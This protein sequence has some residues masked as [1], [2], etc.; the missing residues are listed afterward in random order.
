MRHKRKILVGVVTAVVVVVLGYYNLSGIGHQTIQL[1][2]QLYGSS[3]Y[4][5]HAR[6]GQWPT[7]ADDL[8][9]TPLPKISPYWKVALETGTYVILWPKNLK[10][11]PKD[12]ANVILA[13]HNQGLLASMGRVWVCWGDLRTEYITSEELRTHLPAD[14]E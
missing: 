3:I 1:H 7:Q 14:R 5:Y 10:A 13:Y 8:A 2:L 12:N 9:K 11:D 6:M 4:E